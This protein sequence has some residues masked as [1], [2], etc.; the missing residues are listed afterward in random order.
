VVEASAKEQG[1]SQGNLATKIDALAEAG[2]IREATRASAHEIRLVGNEVAHGD[3]A[4]DISAEESEEVL[5]LMDEI[6]VELFQSQA[7]RER[8]RAAREARR[9]RPDAAR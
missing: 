9:S 7:R 3:L 1:H 4:S 5:V 8:A 6:L 2:Q